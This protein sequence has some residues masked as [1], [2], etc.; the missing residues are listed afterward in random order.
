MFSLFRSISV[1]LLGSIG[2]T[3]VFSC[4]MMDLSVGAVYGLSSMVAGLPESFLA[5]GG[6]G[7]FGLYWSI[8]IAIIF[9]I[10]AGWVLK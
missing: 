7:P 9:A 8:Y 3:F 2:A 4:G 1:T 5:M 10:I 6:K